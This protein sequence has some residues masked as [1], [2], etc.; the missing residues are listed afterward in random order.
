V[1]SKKP[2]WKL[3]LKRSDGSMLD[4]DG[5]YQDVTDYGKPVCNPAC[6]RE[7]CNSYSCRDDK[8]GWLCSAY[9]DKRIVPKEELYEIKDADFTIEAEMK[10]AG[11]YRGR[12]AAGFYLKDIKTGATY[13][14][15]MACLDDLLRSEINIVNGQIKGRWGFLKTGANY[16]IKWLGQQAS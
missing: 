6:V 4:W 9:P 8:N 7:G 15:R 3:Y 16:S 1:S 13:V 5:A 12:S 14:I 10:F 11:Y 2:G